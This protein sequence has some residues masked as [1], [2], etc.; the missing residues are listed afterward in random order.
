[1]VSP[2]VIGAG[3][4][5]IR[6]AMQLYLTLASQANMTEADI[7]KMLAAERAKFYVNRPDLLPKPPEE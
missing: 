3:V 1:M 2:I 5:V 4:E 7:D 6:M